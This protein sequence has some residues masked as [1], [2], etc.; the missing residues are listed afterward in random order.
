MTRPTAARTAF[1]VAAV[2]IAIYAAMDALMK[3][4][5]ITSGAYAAVLWRSAAGIAVLGPIF[6]ARRTPWPNVRA[7]KLHIARGVTSGAS[8]LLFFWGL[9]RVPMA[10]GVALTFLA[11]LMALFLAAVLLGERIRRVAITGS[12]IASVGVCVIAAGQVQAQVSE[13][14]VMA[15]SPFW[16]HRSCTRAA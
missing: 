10:Q 2:G 8:V 9:V 13:A 4:L 11:P 3:G 12:I 5:S 16:P 1:L 14:S 15:A 7:L 6:L